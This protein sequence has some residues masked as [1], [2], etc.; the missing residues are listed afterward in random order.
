MAKETTFLYLDPGLH[1]LLIRAP[2]HRPVR[3]QRRLENGELVSLHPSLRRATPRAAALALGGLAGHPGDGH[4]PRCPGAERGMPRTVPA[5]VATEPS[6][7]A[8]A[9]R[10][11][12]RVM[13]G[14]ATGFAPLSGALAIA[15]VGLA[16]TADWSSA[17]A[18]RPRTTAL[19]TLGGLRLMTWEDCHERCQSAARNPCW[20]A[21]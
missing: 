14:V 7:D 12:I 6:R 18:D 13:A 2:G 19:T 17:R 8:F 21:A 15:T 10:D 5:G 9:T 3:W 20:P 1:R 11:R 16:L 4:R